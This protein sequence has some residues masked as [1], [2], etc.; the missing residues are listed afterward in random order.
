MDFEVE[1]GH[2]GWF[3]LEV[4]R[5]GG[6]LFN[7][8]IE[9]RLLGLIDGEV[10]VDQEMIDDLYQA[11]VD[12]A[13]GTLSRRAAHILLEQQ[14][15]NSHISK[16]ESLLDELKSGADFAALASEHSEDFITAEQ[17]GDLGFNQRGDLPEVL[18]TVPLMPSLF[19]EPFADH[20]SLPMVGLCRHAASQVK[21]VLSGDGGDE[22]H[23]GYGRYVKY[24][25]RLFQANPTI[26][27]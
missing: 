22:T 10:S 16:I 18:E 4:E 15:D 7:L 3:D 20:S 17:G 14:E 9:R 19:D 6:R 1:L 24:G 25:R 27:T 12:A 21:V 2:L 23:A 5:R 11:R 13:E 26:E 8:K